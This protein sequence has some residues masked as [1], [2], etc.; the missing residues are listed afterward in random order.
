MGM[1]LVLKELDIFS[2]YSN[3]IKF[4]FQ[5]HLIKLISLIHWLIDINICICYINVG[6]KLRW[7]LNPQKSC[8]RHFEMPNVLQ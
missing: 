8:G 2:K 7:R 4:L 1:S 6:S 5:Y 3:D